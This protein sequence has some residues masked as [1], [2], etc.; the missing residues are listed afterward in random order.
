MNVIPQPIETL[1]IDTV[2]VLCA[3]AIQKANSGH[4]GTA[5][6]LALDCTCTLDRIYALQF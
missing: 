3:D 6:A 2:R 5:M 4:P 1:T